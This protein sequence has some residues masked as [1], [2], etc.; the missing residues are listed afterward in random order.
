MAHPGVLAL[1]GELVG[2]SDDPPAGDQ[3][4]DG[5]AYRRMVE[6]GVGQGLFDLTGN[7]VSGVVEEGQSSF[8]GLVGAVIGASALAA[9]PGRRSAWLCRTVQRWS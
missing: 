3:L 7:E 1:F 6:L 2:R 5:G 8:G 4:G 9:R